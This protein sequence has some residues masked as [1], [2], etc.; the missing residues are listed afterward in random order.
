V[1]GNQNRIQKFYNS[2]QFL[3]FS[4]GI[5]EILKKCGTLA[6]SCAIMTSYFEKRSNCGY[7]V[8]G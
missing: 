7:P 3:K 6:A 1:Q 5:Q 8:G 4:E 2:N